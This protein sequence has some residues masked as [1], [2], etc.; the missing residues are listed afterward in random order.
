MNGARETKLPT[1]LSAIEEYD[2]I[3][4][5]HLEWQN[6]LELELGDTL[7]IKTS[8]ALVVIIFLATQS[9]GFLAT[10]MPRHWHNLQ[11]V[12][13]LCLIIAGVLAV[14]ELIPRTY[15]F[16]L[17]PAKFLEW[18]KGVKDFYSADGVSNPEARSVEF[19]RRKQIE[20]MQTRFSKN[21][22]IN[23]M[24]SKAVEWSFYLTMTALILN[25]AT[26]AALTSDWR[27]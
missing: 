3:I 8:I 19:I 11:I 14:W 16:G 12:S 23:A 4:Q 7:D 9:G 20:Q 27:F 24:K 26:L 15:K 17:S 18:V 1:E 6:E 21:R 22:A 5:E 10:H 2:L 13:V 25:L